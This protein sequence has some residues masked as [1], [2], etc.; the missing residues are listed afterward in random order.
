MSRK[1]FEKM[2]GERLTFTATVKRSGLKSAYKGADIKTWLFVDVRLNGQLVADHVWFTD[3]KWSSDLKR[4]DKIS[5]DARIKQYEKGYKG[6]DWEAKADNPVSI[7]YKLS[8][9]SKVKVLESRGR[10]TTNAITKKKGM[11]HSY[12]HQ[13]GQKISRLHILSALDG[14]ASEVPLTCL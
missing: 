11:G 8:H 14:L 5:F 3:G 12:S 4:G 1:A 7:D 2:D 10:E 13:D 9:P 6:Y